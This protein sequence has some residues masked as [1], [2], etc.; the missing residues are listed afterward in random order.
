[1]KGLESPIV[2]AIKC[3]KNAATRPHQLPQEPHGNKELIRYKNTYYWA[4][5]W[6]N[7]NSA[8]RNINNVINNKESHT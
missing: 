8:L 5:D 1:M 7:R 2:S 4:N 6:R 3:N